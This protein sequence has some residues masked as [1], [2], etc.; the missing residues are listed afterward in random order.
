MSEASGNSN[1]SYLGSPTGIASWLLTHDH[2][3]IGLMFLLAT[4]GAMFLGGL[5]ALLV[6]LELLAPGPTIMG[7]EMYNRLFTLHGVTMVWL[8]MIPAIP[9]GLG[10]FLVPLMIGAR[11]V[12]FPRLNLL[13]LYVYLLGAA[14][15]LGGMWWGGTDTGWTFYVPYSVKTASALVPVLLG[16]FVL[17]ISSI[18]TGLNFIVTIHTLRIRGLRWMKQPLFVWSIYATS[19]ILVLATPVL[20]MTLGL[21]GIDHLFDWGLF[22]PA[23]GGDPVLY[24]HLFWFYSHPAVYIMILPAMGVVTEVVCSFARK[25]PFSYKAIAFS[26]LGIAFVGFTT[27][28][29]HMFTAG[30]SAF[31]AGAF[32]LLSML[33]AVFSAIKVFSW[34]GTLKGGSIHLSAPLLHILTFLFLFVFGGMTGVAV[35]T[36]SLD[37]HWHDT[38]FIVAH[39]HF[40]MVGGTLTAFLAGLHYWFPKL[41]G[42]MYPERIAKVAAGLVFIGFNVT[43]VPQ[44]LLGNRGMP[45]R[46]F[47]YPEP[48]HLLNAVS[49]VGAGVLGGTLLLIVGYL[50]VAAFFGRRSGDNPF[51]SASIEWRTSSPPH[52]HNFTT[53]PDIARGTY[54]YHTPS[55]GLRSSPDRSTR[56]LA[57]DS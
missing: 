35:A 3:R 31:D 9:S 29:H 55:S 41:T 46:Y 2:K 45:R 39:F 30:M 53:L 15:T 26:T 36:T 25:N 18:M 48:F 7:A 23:R 24:Q 28:G 21:I 32:G 52:P 16:V 6:R 5:F 8:F 51:D 44:F 1:R 43:F 10:N 12:A 13:S 19:I 40:I 17:G 14:I 27:W 11:D 38:Y 34:V 20:G 50:T 42:R 57:E 56:S 33:V 22:D 54:D 49:S 37:V 4:S 47:D